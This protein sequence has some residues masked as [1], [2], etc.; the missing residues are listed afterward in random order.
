MAGCSTGREQACGT[1]LTN[2]IERDA[3]A[4]GASRTD[5]VAARRATDSADAMASCT[6]GCELTR[7]G[8]SACGVETV[9]VGG[10]G[11]CAQAI[12]G[13]ARSAGKCSAIAGAVSG[14]DER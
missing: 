7:A 13:C 8:A 9:A 14:H 6:T 1:A 5:S 12:A 4:G 11:D 10:S 2:E 3:I